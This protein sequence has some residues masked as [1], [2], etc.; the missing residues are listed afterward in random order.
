MGAGVFELG[1]RGQPEADPHSERQGLQRALDAARHTQYEEQA[2]DPDVLIADEQTS[3]LD[4]LVQA[5]VLDVFGELQWR[6][7]FACLFIS[8]NLAVAERSP[9][10]RRHAPGSD[11]AGAHCS[12]ARVAMQEYTR[13]LL[14][15]APVADPTVQAARRA[16]RPETA[17]DP[18]ARQMTAGSK[19]PTSSVSL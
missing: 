12:G 2:R 15:A 7:G 3:A 9:N 10:G 8:H 14:A 13:R 11:R 16:G 5:R 19:L 17:L 1:W 4:V 6:L 18:A